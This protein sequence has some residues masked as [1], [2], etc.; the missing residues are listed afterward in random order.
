MKIVAAR[1]AETNY[2]A[3]GLINYDPAVDVYLTDT[4]IAQAE[5]LAKELKDFHFDAIYVSRL[6]RTKQTAKIINYYHNLNLI[7]DAL[8]DDIRN[9]F[10]GKAA[11]EAKNWRSAQPDPAAARYSREY[12]SVNDMTKRARAFLEK[13]KNG[14]AADATILVVTSSHLIKQFKLLNGDMSLDELLGTRAK[15]ASYYVFEI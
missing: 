4:G 2:N 7:E 15:N 3:L 13:I 10:E 12:E 1:H 9:G 14:H 8:L 11:Q 6:K 5:E